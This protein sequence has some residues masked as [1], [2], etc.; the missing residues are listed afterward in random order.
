MVTVLIFKGKSF[1]RYGLIILSDFFLL[2]V[3]I[4]EIPNAERLAVLVLHVWMSDCAQ[5]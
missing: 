3:R 1:H 2:L 5:K 4:K